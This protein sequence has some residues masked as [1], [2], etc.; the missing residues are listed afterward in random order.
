MSLAVRSPLQ[1]VAKGAAAVGKSVVKKPSPNAKATNTAP[2]PTLRFAP[3]PAP[4]LAT[5]NAKAT[6]AKAAPAPARTAA[7]RPDVVD[8]PEGLSGIAAR[9]AASGHPLPLPGAGFTP[10]TLAKSSGT[11]LVTPTAPTVPVTP[12]NTP[13][14][15]PPLLD[16]LP[17]TPNFND[18]RNPN[19]ATP[20][21]N[22]SGAG[23]TQ[24]T[25]P[26]MT[27]LQQ[28]QDFGNM[29]LP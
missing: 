19:M 18:I 8:V 1:A 21:P 9:R 15:P 20:I 13:I 14:A 2:A 23:A 27:L 28:M 10:P 25:P 11:P 4:P 7:V 22:G 24:G 6:P 12:P 3:P 17:P 29:P 16:A 5:P 26:W